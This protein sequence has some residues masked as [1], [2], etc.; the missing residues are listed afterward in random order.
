[1]QPPRPQ[2]NVHREPAPISP[3]ASV[4]ATQGLPT[5]RKLRTEYPIPIPPTLNTHSFDNFS[6][7]IS[8]DTDM[9]N[10][11]GQD[12][13]D[14]AMREL[15][16]KTTQMNQEVFT[17]LLRLGVDETHCRPGLSSKWSYSVYPDP[18]LKYSFS[19]ISAV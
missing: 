15:S 17:Q 9:L 19:D 1:M 16:P 14:D 4:L 6:Q 18:L 12:Y 10:G 5:A 11:T 2:M 3:V 7:K 8:L 13:D